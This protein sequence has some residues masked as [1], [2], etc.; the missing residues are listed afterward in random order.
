MNEHKWSRRA[1]FLAA[2]VAIIASTSGFALASFLSPPTTVNQTA[3]FYNGA[4][5]Q[6]AGFSTPVLAIAQTPNGVAGCSPEQDT[7]SAVMDVTTGGVATLVL[8]AYDGGSNCT[9]GNFAVEF[10][11]DYFLDPTTT[12]DL[13][14]T[15]YS[16]VPGGQPFE[17]NYGHM[18]LGPATSGSF[19]ATVQV[20]VD[21]GQVNPINVEN[22]ELSIHAP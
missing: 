3:S 14:F 1:V 19:G 18:M 2:A 6:V 4:D 11:F 17:T 7:N 15:I 10:S 21:Y 16:Q 13:N 8:S 20:F 9:T 22:L 12:H 5:V